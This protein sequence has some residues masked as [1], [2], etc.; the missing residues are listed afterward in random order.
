MEIKRLD[1]VNVRTEQL[2]AMVAW[3]TETLGMKKGPR[4][5][6][7]SRGAWMYIGDHPMVHLVGVDEDAGVGSEQALKLEHFAFAASGMAAFEERLTA[8]GQAYRC[9]DVPDTTL[10]QFNVWDPDGNHIHVDFDRAA[11][12]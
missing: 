3:Y 4:P 1:H 2:E 12:V 5:A 10:T 8:S 9:I 11:E 6:F 7:A